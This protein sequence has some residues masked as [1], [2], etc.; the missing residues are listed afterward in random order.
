[1]G[2]THSLAA[3]ITVNTHMRLGRYLRHLQELQKILYS[4][5]AA[6]VSLAD[7]GAAGFSFAEGR[8]EVAP[9]MNEMNDPIVIRSSEYARRNKVE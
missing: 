3:I 2:K 8:P 1:M 9:S 7:L 5:R 4:L 6:A